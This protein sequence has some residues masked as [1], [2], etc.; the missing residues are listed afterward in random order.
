M[1]ITALSSSVVELIFL[2]L[3]GFAAYLMKGAVA[4]FEERTAITLEEVH[5]NTLQQT[6][7]AALGYAEQ[8]AQEASKELLPGSIDLKN[9][10]LNTAAS[11]VSECV[12]DTLAYFGVTRERL[13]HM[14]EARLN[15]DL[16]QDG[17]IGS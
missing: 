13:I 9:E 7:Y 4:A 16:N 8:R 10:L 15:F 3:G 17:A 11:Y 14:L 5:K 1:D 2:I 12:P 6:L